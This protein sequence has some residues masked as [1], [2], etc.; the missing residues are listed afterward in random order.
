MTC[1][2]ASRG[3]LAG[4]LWHGLVTTPVARRAAATAAA[5]E[6]PGRDGGPPCSCRARRSARRRRRRARVPVLAGLGTDRP[7]RPAVVRGRPGRIGGLVWAASPLP[8]LGTLLLPAAPGAAA[9]ACAVVAPNGWS[10][11]RPSGSCAPS[12][13][14]ATPE[15]AR[16]AVEEF[17]RVAHDLAG[18]GVEQAA[19]VAFEV[20]AAALA[21]Q[22]V[23]AR[24]SCPRT[25]PAAA[26][27]ASAGA[28]AA[29]ARRPDSWRPQPAPR[30][31]VPGRASAAARS[32][33]MRV[34]GRI[35]AAR[36]ADRAATPRR[37]ACRPRGP[38][39]ATAAR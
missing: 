9:V 20:H 29:G 11:A 14:T 30:R 10:R 34:D 23:G 6:A 7:R 16:S 13:G 22:R 33:P 25:R 31:P 12:P 38:P 24:R 37:G 2:R 8:V 32:S 35:R 3:G 28:A 19:V 1:S 39:R 36:A 5:G 21:Q 17:P 27:P 15:A 26:A 4:V 18:A